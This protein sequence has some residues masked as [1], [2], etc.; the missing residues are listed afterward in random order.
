MF[1]YNGLSDAVDG[2]DVSSKTVLI[3]FV[4]WLAT[5]GLTSLLLMVAGA[6][7]WRVLSVPFLIVNL[8][9]ILAGI[10]A[11]IV[12]IKN[13]VRIRKTEKRMSSTF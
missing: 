6:K 4:V 7:K 2:R 10:W 5:L 1:F 11:L 13:A 3:G 8:L 9:L 12:Y